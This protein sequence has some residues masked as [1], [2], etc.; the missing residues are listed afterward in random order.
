MP[1]KKRTVKKSVT[2]DNGGKTVTKTVKRKSGAEVKK[3]TRKHGDGSFD[4]TVTK[5]KGG[6]TKTRAFSGQ[7]SI[8]ENWNAADHVPE[9]RSKATAAVSSKPNYNQPMKN[10]TIDRFHKKQQK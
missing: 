9:H 8:D 3:V 1:G 5:T 4:K 2:K 10:R 6:K 7:G